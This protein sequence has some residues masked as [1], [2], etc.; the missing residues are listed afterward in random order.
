MLS[1]R[2]Q[3]GFAGALAALLV[4]AL[5][6]AGCGGGDDGSGGGESAAAN[7]GA[8]LGG[9]AAVEKAEGFGSEASRSEAKSAEAA[10]LGYQRARAAGE[11]SKACSYLSKDLRQAYDQLSRGGGC[12]GFVEKTTKRLSAEE[13]SALTELEVES[14]RVEGD[15]G[16]VIYA[17][18]EGSQQAKPIAAEGGAWKLSSLLV[19]FLEKNQK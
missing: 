17:D 14:V 6:L 9:A 13:R 19:Q 5:L 1:S 15:S 4:F 18:A 10:L 12:G 7:G 8:E 11:W 16:Y 3:G 2:R